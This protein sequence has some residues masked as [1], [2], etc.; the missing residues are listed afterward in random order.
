MN[1]EGRQAMDGVEKSG[2]VLRTPRKARDIKR[3]SKNKRKAEPQDG[4]DV[5]AICDDGG[6]VTCCD[7]GCLR[8]FHLT[9]EHGEGSK[10]PSL[11]L[12]S[13]QAKMIIGKK[14]FICKNCK[15]KQ[16]QCSACGLLGS[17]DLS[18]GAEVFKC[19]DYACGHFYHP[20]CI[21][22]LRHP[23]SKVRA[24]LFEQ[25]VAAG[26]KFLCHVHKCSVCHGEE[27]KDDKDMQFAVC[28][29]CP[30]TYHRKCLP[31]DIPFAAKEGPNG[32]IFQRA[33]DGILRD[34]ILIYCMKHEIIKELGIPRRKLIIFPEAKNFFAPKDPESTP[35]EQDILF[36]QELLGHP[37]SEPSQTPP[38]PATVQNQCFRSNPM[39]SFAPS[40]LYTD[41]YA[42][43]CGWVDD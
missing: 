5:C 41:P 31:S 28:R 9:E 3:K 33:W 14:A 19:K 36:E 22:E 2:H 8:S 13:E 10:C 38:P 34:Q 12:T 1:C 40:S 37:A 27:N 20:K 32:Y 7:G 15:Y 25:H 42:G 39:D 35:K 23:D 17:S 43:S 16:H 26:L 18:S 6:F 24:S 11:G 4:D 29:L 21:S 30:T